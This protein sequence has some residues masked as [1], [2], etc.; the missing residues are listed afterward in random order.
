MQLGDQTDNETCYYSI[1][2]QL[3]LLCL[4]PHAYRYSTDYHRI[5]IVSYYLEL[6]KLLCLSSIRLLGYIIQ[7]SCD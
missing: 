3:I 2:E 4:S 7:S 1:S 5:P 6:N